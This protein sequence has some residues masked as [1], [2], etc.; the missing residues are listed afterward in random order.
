[1]KLVRLLQAN[2]T[3]GLTFS[4]NEPIEL[5]PESQVALQECVIDVQGTVLTVDATNNVINFSTQGADGAPQTATLD[6]GTY[7]VDA[8]VREVTRALNAGLDMTSGLGTSAQNLQWKA[9]MDGPKLEISFDRCDPAV[10]SQRTNVGGTMDAANQ[11]FTKTTATGIAFDA[12]S[13]SRQSL[14]KGAGYYM[15][16]VQAI[17]PTLTSTNALGLST[18]ATPGAI[19]LT[20]LAKCIY[21]DRATS[22]YFVQDGGGAFTD[23]GVIAAVGDSYGFRVNNGTIRIIYQ[24]AGADVT[25]ALFPATAYDQTVSLFPLVAMAGDQNSTVSINGVYHATDP[26]E[27]A[28]FQTEVGRKNTTTITLHFEKN[29]SS[30]AADLLGFNRKLQRIDNSGAGTFSAGSVL[31][32]TSKNLSIA[33]LLDSMPS[34]QSYDSMAGG[35]RPILATVSTPEI[36]NTRIMYQPANLA[37][38]DIANQHPM[39]I[40]SFRIRVVD[41]DNVDM[42]LSDGCSFTLLF[43]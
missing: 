27:V 43:K 8:L 14:I 38:L 42:A 31:V 37:W 30:G 25:F 20:T 24:R 41:T 15:L 32:A 26:F 28:A 19:D 16:D 7:D 1:M 2:S 13:T 10:F 40:S 4:L 18:L 5:H 23:T 21:V 11:V 33:V 39:S 34:I 36:A 35:R 3:G 22:H 17:T 29:T 12:W 9:T 6:V